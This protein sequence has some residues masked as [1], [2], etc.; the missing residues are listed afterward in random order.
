MRL[1]HGV[2]NIIAQMDTPT[3][4]VP[5]CSGLT[6][7]AIRSSWRPDWASMT[8]EEAHQRARECTRRYALPLTWSAD[9]SV[10]RLFSAEFRRAV[11][12]VYMLQRRAVRQES[13]N[14]FPRL[15]RVLINAIIGFLSPVISP[16]P[17]W[18]L[19]AAQIDAMR[20]RSAAG[21]EGQHSAAE[22]PHFK[23]LR[24]S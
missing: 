14:R 23:R 2:L 13:T 11:R 10:H 9:P 24:T 19:S 22:Q 7:D 4:G 21:D 3:L 20:G 5:I 12:C 6:N 1:E 8:T 18:V 17:L 16:P 15:P